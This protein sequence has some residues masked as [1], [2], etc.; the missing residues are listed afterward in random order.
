MVSATIRPLYSQKTTL[1]SMEQENRWAP[2]PV[3]KFW[4]RR[5][6]LY[7]TGIR[8]PNRPACKKSL[9]ILPNSQFESEPE[10]ECT[11]TKVLRDFLKSLQEFVKIVPE[12]D[13]DCFLWNPFGFILSI[14]PTADATNHE[15]KPAL[16]FAN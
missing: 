14:H 15:N 7:T 2:Q 12:L 11:V 3:C 6:S 13:Q 16:G 8:T 9:F 10:Y 1:V 5:R 4:R